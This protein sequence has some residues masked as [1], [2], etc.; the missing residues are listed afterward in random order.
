[1]GQYFNFYWNTALELMKK[2]SENQSPTDIFLGQF[3]ETVG[4]WTAWLDD[5]TLEMLCR[6]PQPGLWSLGQLYVHIIDDTGYFIEQIKAALLTDADSEKEMHEDAR[7]I[8][9]NNGFPDAL[10]TGPSTGVSIRQPQSKD[11]LL[12][13]L[14]FIKEEVNRLYAAYD[15]SVS[16]GKTSHPGFHFFSASEWLKF[17]EMHMRHHFR[18]KKRIDDK[19]FSV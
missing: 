11:E 4:K 19:L 5:Y 1:M 17:A 8:F 12:Q 14:T 9:G 7:A 18:Q 3:N 13:S 6:E 2:M 10:L 15:F 16:K